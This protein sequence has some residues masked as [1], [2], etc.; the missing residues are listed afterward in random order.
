MTSGWVWVE[1]DFQDGDGEG[2]TALDRLIRLRRNE[3][4][5]VAGVFRVG[6]VTSFYRVRLS[7]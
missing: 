3:E 7:H 6:S 1:V 4:K 5:S 2:R